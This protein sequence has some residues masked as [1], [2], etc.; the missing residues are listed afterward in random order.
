M[1]D[2]VIVKWIIFWDIMY[3]IVLVMFGKNILKLYDWFKVKFV[4]MIFIIEVK[5]VV[6]IEYKWLFSEKNL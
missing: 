6:L 5:C 2:F 4:E 1:G 3:C